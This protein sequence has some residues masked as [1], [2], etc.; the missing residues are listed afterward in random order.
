MKRKY[1]SIGWFFDAVH[2][3]FQYLVDDYGFSAPKHHPYRI[4]GE[5]IYRTRITSVHVIFSHRDEPRAVNVYLTQLEK[6]R[7]PVN[8][9]L[10]TRGIVEIMEVS[11]SAKSAELEVV[12]AGNDYLASVSACA[13]AVKEYASDI[14]LGDFSKFDITDYC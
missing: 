13:K 6:G 2:A 14:L 9:V 12:L 3:D 7:E 11:N 8:M 10:H 1:I 5:V 4:D